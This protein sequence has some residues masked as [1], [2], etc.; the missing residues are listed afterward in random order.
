MSKQSHRE[1]HKGPPDRFAFSRVTV[2]KN[3]R[4]IADGIERILVV[5]EN[6]RYPQAGPMAA[7]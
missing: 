3:A 4:L 5:E 2:R 1:A 7:R 6:R